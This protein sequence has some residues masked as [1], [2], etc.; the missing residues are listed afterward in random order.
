MPRSGRF[1]VLLLARSEKAAFGR[2]SSINASSFGAASQV[3]DRAGVVAKRQPVAHS[4]CL[5]FFDERP[6]PPGRRRLRARPVPRCGRTG[7]RRP[8]RACRRDLQARLQST[9]D[10][11]GR[12]T[13][14]TSAVGNTLWLRPIA[15]CTGGVRATGARRE[16]GSNWLSGTGG[17]NVTNAR[18]S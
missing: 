12:I 18:V 3:L 17:A 11:C 14:A 13:D 6:A 10:T 1:R 15:S 4:Q 8:P 16:S 9:R 5:A 2:A 7:W